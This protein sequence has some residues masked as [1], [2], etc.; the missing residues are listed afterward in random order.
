MSRTTQV[1]YKRNINSKEA[2]DYR[3]IDRLSYS[4][5]KMYADDRKLFKKA[6]IDKEKEEI[7][8]DYIRLGDVVDCLLT[9]RENFDNLFLA[10]GHAMLGISQGAATG[11]II[12][13]LV[14]KTAPEIDI[15]AFRVERF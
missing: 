14:E 7:D 12:S 13:D 6:F 11:K 2:S 15:S 3:K 1:E 10:G 4:L 5:L 8:S 9:D